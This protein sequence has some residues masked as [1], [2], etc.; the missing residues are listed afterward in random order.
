MSYTQRWETERKFRIVVRKVYESLKET[1]KQPGPIRSW[2][3]KKKYISSAFLAVESIV[4]MARI[5]TIEDVGVLADAQTDLDSSRRSRIMAEE[6]ERAL[7][8]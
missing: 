1:P 2:I 3:L 6:F 5:L 7:S 8:L 4:G